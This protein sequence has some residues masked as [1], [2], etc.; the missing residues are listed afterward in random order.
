MK[1]ILSLAL[2]LLGALGASACTPAKKEIREVESMNLQTLDRIDNNHMFSLKAG[3]MVI[4]G[5]Q[6]LMENTQCSVDL[7]A[8]CIYVKQ[9][10]LEL[11]TPRSNYGIKGSL[12]LYSCPMITFEN[13]SRNK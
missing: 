9:D 13:D 1:K 11:C 3:E 7:D 5:L 2:I 12:A 10:F 6:Q 4:I 8:M